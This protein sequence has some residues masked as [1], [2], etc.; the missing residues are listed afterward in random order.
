MNIE[1]T[2]EQAEAFGRGESITLTPKPK[3][4]EPRMG[5]DWV[6][7][8]YI[9][10]YTRLLKYVKEFGGDWNADWSD[11]RQAKY[12]VRYSHISKVWSM[13]WD[14]TVHIMGTVYMSE[15]CAKDLIAKLNSGEVTL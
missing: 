13:S 10:T 8:A 1:L 5:L 6:D 2:L 15:D 14:M 7:R 11:E 3:Q 9:S 4:W 12:S